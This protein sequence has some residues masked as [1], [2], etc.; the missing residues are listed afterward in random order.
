MR[1]WWSGGERFCRRA[2]RPP[3]AAAVAGRHVRE[4]TVICPVLP[5]FRRYI[6]TAFS[7]T[8]TRLSGFPAGCVRG[9]G[10]SGEKGSRTRTDRCWT[11]NSVTWTTTGVRLDNSAAADA[12]SASFIGQIEPT[13][14]R[15]LEGIERKWHC[16]LAAVTSSSSSIRSTALCQPLRH[17][18]LQSINCMRSFCWPGK[19]TTAYKGVSAKT[20]SIA[21][22]T[23]C[24]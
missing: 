21:S 7:P 13:I 14:R 15:E 6:I 12:K 20:V 23:P 22:K 9:G 2:D 3:A 1:K 24:L 11:L 19:S 18:I 5:T 16:N 4:W 8:P 17:F 10:R